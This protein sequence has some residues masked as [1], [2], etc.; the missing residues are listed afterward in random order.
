MILLALMF[1]G[2]AV[3]LAAPPGSAQTTPT[4]G[5]AF[6]AT[7]AGDGAR[8]SVTVVGAPLTDNP[9]DVAFPTAQVQA[10]SLGT[11][12][13]YAA[14]PDPGTLPQ[15]A[16]GLVVGL[17][18]Q[19]GTLGLPPIHIPSLPGYPLSVEAVRGVNP[20]QSVGQGP[21][22]LSASSEDSSTSASATGGLSL[23][24]SGQTFGLASNA[25]ITQAPN[26]DVVAE[27]TTDVQ[28][29]AIG[30]LTIGNLVS[31]ARITLGTDGTVTRFREVHMGGVQIG[32]VAVSISTSGLNVAGNVVPAPV[33]P[34]L[35][36]LLKGAG[37]TFSLL[38]AQDF[39]NRVIAPA[40]ELTVPVSG[41]IV[42]AT[43]G[44]MV[45]TVGGATAFMTAAVPPGT[46]VGDVVP[47][48]TPTGSVTLP[49]GAGS[50][51]L[52]PASSPAGSSSVGSSAAPP[53]S[54]LGSARPASS[55]GGVAVPLGLWDIRVLYLLVVA[56]AV[57]AWL[58]GHVF[59]LLGVRRP[60]KSSVG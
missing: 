13:G 12:M 24:G 27:A 51:V 7:A 54:A 39:P 4:S 2:G 52:A 11:G 6:S 41:K 15:T 38:P 8:V 29:L 26:G 21:Y 10:N 14:F 55:V 58:M 20:T 47:T 23:G 53:Q 35:A 22:T 37:I 56:C 44:T 42:G 17:L 34:A 40:V 25:D 30:P 36:T 59:R 50:S 49:S 16:P 46:A 32:G 57:G 33:G 60:W 28:G 1:L 45:V 31:T 3:A 18:G 19:G 43:S 48:F 5:P 9:V